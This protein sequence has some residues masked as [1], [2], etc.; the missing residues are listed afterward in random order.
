MWQIFLG[1]LVLSLIHGL[2]PNHWIPLVLISKTEKWNIKETISATV[3]TGFSH[4]MSTIIIGIIVGFIG[5]KLSE[6]YNYITKVAA[7]IVLILVGI[8]YIL[9]DLRSSHHH[10]HFDI[11]NQ[12]IKNKKSKLVIIISLSIAMFFS[13]CL[14]IEAYYFQAASLGW[15]GILIVSTVYL[16]IT[17]SL[18]VTLVYLGLK[19]INRFN[20]HFLEHHE[21]RISGIVLILLGLFAYFFE[22]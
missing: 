17:L 16:F 8:I 9:I 6:S 3:I 2:I 13:P 12:P 14:E 18:M 21:K 22:F 15:I 4:M 20:W 5:I 11:N 7:P 10:H 19:G 1:S